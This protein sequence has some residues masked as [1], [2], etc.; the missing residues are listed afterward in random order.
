MEAK[1]REAF[2]AIAKAQCTETGKI[3]VDDHDVTANVGTL[4][5][6]R[7]I[8]LEHSQAELLRPCWDLHLLYTAWLKFHRMWN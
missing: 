7:A 3:W 8:V 5:H 4:E 6:Y 1:S 2:D